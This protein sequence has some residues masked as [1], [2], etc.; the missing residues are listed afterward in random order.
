ML[1]KKNIGKPYAGEPL[2][3]FDEGTLGNVLICI[4]YI[5]ALH[6]TLF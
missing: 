3:R 2:V 1:E 5:V 6:S 4:N